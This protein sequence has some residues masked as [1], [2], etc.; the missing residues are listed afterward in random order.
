MSLQFELLYCH[1]ESLLWASFDGVISTAHTFVIALSGIAMLHEQLYLGFLFFWTY[2]EALWTASALHALF[3]QDMPAC[4]LLDEPLF[5]SARQAR[6]MPSDEALVIAAVTSFL[7]IH[8]FF[9]RR[10]LPLFVE[11]LL[12]VLLPLTLLSL[13]ATRN[14]TLAQL[15]VGLG[16]GLLLGSFSALIY[17]FFYK[18]HLEAEREAFHLNWLVPT[19]AQIMLARGEQPDHD[20]KMLKPE[21]FAL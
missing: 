10:I 19:G 5:A 6:G 9:V 17:H 8:Q 18:Y 2:H 20:T 7:L 14:A 16:V 12:V 15:A 1:G 13:Y 4:S 21:L 11:L 3:P